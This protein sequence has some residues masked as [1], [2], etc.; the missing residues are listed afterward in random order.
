M[1]QWAQKGGATGVLEPQQ[2][3]LVKIYKT[4]V[5]GF[6]QLSGGRSPYQTQNLDHLGPMCFWSLS[7]SLP[8][9]VYYM[10]VVV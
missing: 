1:V 8:M 9:R 10:K 2:F 7:A 4:N 5:A 6:H 3:I